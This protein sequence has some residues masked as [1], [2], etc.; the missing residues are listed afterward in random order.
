M[1]PRPPLRTR[2]QML[3]RMHRHLKLRIQQRTHLA[4]RSAEEQRIHLAVELAFGLESLPFH[5]RGGGRGVVGGG[6]MRDVVVGAGLGILGSFWVERFA[7]EFQ[8]GLGGVLAP[9]LDGAG[10]NGREVGWLF[11]LRG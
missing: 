8:F 11:V 7:V 9:G 5:L 1:L 6:V 4:V 10:E 3:N 2:T